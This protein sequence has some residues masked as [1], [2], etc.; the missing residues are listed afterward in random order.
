MVGSGALTEHRLVGVDTSL[1]IHAFERHAV[2]GERSA[3]ILRSIEVRRPSVVASTLLIAE[4]LVAPFTTGRLELVD[5]YVD[6]LSVLPNLR[7]IPPDVAICRTAARLRAEAL[8]DFL[9]EWEA[10]HGPL[11]PDDGSPYSTPTST[12]K[13]GMTVRR[14]FTVQRSWTKRPMSLAVARVTRLPP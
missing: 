13:P 12:R 4:L 5:D 3:A 6:R 2:F 7:L 14:R 8:A 10:T 1:F 11:T 9:D